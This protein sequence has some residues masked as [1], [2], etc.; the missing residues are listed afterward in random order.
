MS[1][2]PGQWLPWPARPLALY[3]AALLAAPLIAL[4]ITSTWTADLFSVSRDPTLANYLQLVERPLY[5]K[6]IL[7]SFRIGLVV[8]LVTVPVAFVAA[9]ALTFALGRAETQRSRSIAR[10]SG[11]TARH[12][13]GNGL[14]N[15]CH[16][17]PRA[18]FALDVVLRTNLL[19]THKRPECRE[20]LRV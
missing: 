6:L 19:M 12:W 16:N 2:H 14:Q 9:Y 20:H 1:G 4:A 11:K 8:A 5:V 13:P 18:F 10:E 3:L 17:A 7:K 15:R